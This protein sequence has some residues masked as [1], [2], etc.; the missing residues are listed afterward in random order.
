MS[1]PSK[2]WAAVT[3]NLELYM[4]PPHMWYQP[5][6][7]ACCSEIWKGN[8][9]AIASVPPTIWRSGRLLKEGGIRFTE[10]GCRGR[11]FALGGQSRAVDTK[12]PR[13]I[14]SILQCKY[15]EQCN[16]QQIW[17]W[18]LP[19]TQCSVEAIA[20]KQRMKMLFIVLVLK[21]MCLV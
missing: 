10:L 15:R 17:G 21:S 14:S 11:P 9:L 18:Y 8:S 5:P 3:M 2:Q 4:D 6:P 1:Y 13:F 16:K 7:L 12:L 19:R 20:T